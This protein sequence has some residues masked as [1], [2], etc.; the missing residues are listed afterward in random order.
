MD[1]AGPRPRSARAVVAQQR[2]LG[3]DP[4]LTRCGLGCVDVDPRR[5]VR[6][7]EVGVV[8]TPPSQSPELRLLTITEAI[9]DWIARL[10]PSV[11]SIERVFAQ[12]NLRSVIGVAQVMGTAMAT[13]ARAGL[14]VAQHTPSEA[15]AAVTGSGTADKAQV[16]AMVTRILGLDA[17]PRPADAADALAQAICHGWRGGGTGTDDATEMVSAGGA[18]RVSARTPAQRQWAAAQAAARRTGAVDPRRV[19]R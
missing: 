10:G 9:E 17:P 11:V 15:K 19:R 16:Q 18:V 2:V 13:A 4:G 14:E 12:D 8:R 1:L 7:V 5:Q 3:I 6:L